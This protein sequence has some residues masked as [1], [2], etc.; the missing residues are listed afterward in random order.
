M[1]TFDTRK[2]K[3]K[4]YAM[5]MLVFSALTVISSVAL[6]HD[7]KFV[8]DMTTRYVAMA[9]I[10]SVDIIS[11]ALFSFYVMEVY[12]K[13]LMSVLYTDVLTK[14]RNYSK[15]L[16]DAQ[17]MIDD[18]PDKKYAVFYA[19]I[20]NFKYIN[21]TFGYNVGDHILMFIS[22]RLES[23]L[24]NKGGIF[25]R[26]SADNFTVTVEYEDK[27]EFIEIIYSIIDDV[28]WND[29]IQRENYKPEIYVGIFCSGDVDVK[30]NISEMIDRANMAEK[31]IKGS[32]EY[33][34][35]F[36]NEE[37]RERIIA[38]KELERRMDSALANGEFIPYFQPK[39]DVDSGMIVGAEALVR[40]DSPTGF[41]TPAKFIPL[42]EQNGFIINLDQYVFE[43]VCKDVRKWLDEGRKV[44]PISIN[45]SRLQFYR[46]DFVKR[47]TKI[48]DKYDIPDGILELEFTESI[49]FENLELLKK[50][51]MS[52]KKSGFMCSID[53]FGSGY[54]S[55]NILK[56]LP[57][58]TLKLDRLFFKNSENL[59]RDKALVASVVTMARA[60]DMKT[61]A[62]GIETWAQ[63]SFLKEIGCDII[64][65]YV[66]S[67]P[68]PKN[69]FETLV[70][71]GDRK[72]VKLEKF[73]M[74]LDVSDKNPEFVYDKYKACLGLLSGYVAEVNFN[75]NTYVG[76]NEFS[77]GLHSVKTKGDYNEEFTKFVNTNV[78]ADDKNSLL[79]RCLSIGIVSSFYQ[80]EVCVVT[81]FR[82][83]D[84][85][86]DDYVWARLKIKRLCPKAEN[87]FR[88]ILYGEIIE[89]ESSNNS[90]ASSNSKDQID[91]AM[92]NICSFMYEVDLK[93]LR[94]NKIYCDERK[95]GKQPESADISWFVECYLPKL[96]AKDDLE[97]MQHF[98]DPKYMESQLVD[99][100]NSFSTR[101]KLKILDEKATAFLSVGKLSD[102]DNDKKILVVCHIEEDDDSAFGNQDLLKAVV[103]NAINH[104][105]D[106]IV[107]LNVPHNTY[108]TF[109]TA[110]PYNRHPGNNLYTEMLD[111]YLERFADASDFER[112][113]NALDLK[114][115]KTLFKTNQRGATVSFK[116]KSGEDIYETVDIIIMCIHDKSGEETAVGMI[117]LNEKKKNAKKK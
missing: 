114:A 4:I 54:S 113:R 44:V 77:I 37:I 56:N 34:I 13:K 100:N 76:L 30:Y 20:Q 48:K 64:Q 33:H 111:S 35:A 41:M 42:F 32:F 85:S 49:V 116:S 45:V 11:T 105:A 71:G 88:A 47:Y 79:K 46:L 10:I 21:D 9:A 62:E 29:E 108:S 81:D 96:V 2:A 24:R 90:I 86:K 39:Y 102:A 66:Y 12:D 63:V 28:C 53:D 51:V 22:E 89:K 59:E 7:M 75:E 43:T 82:V 106:I 103:S 3:N 55:L 115:I 26:I 107:T 78:H 117:R 112:V 97:R 92:E 18:N 65:G 67:E 58:D 110:P 70:E 72:A 91:S 69:R 40:W 95:V 50:I 98:F 94:F 60:L 1:E 74:P 87:D 104:F 14:G 73:K 23:T 31:S 57:M 17:K 36:Y 16:V 84:E 38:E 61:V 19:D 109:E 25:A 93:A 15:Y 52:L 80:G 27:N 83:F 8:D 101:C 6:N 99:G 68:I 5:M